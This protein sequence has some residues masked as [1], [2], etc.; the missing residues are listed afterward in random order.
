MTDEGISISVKEVQKKKV[1][2]AILLIEGSFTSVNEE[3]LRNALFSIDLTVE[4]I[5]IFFNKEHPENTN[6]C[7]LWTDEGIVTSVNEEQ[8]AKV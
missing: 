6:S 3:H 2:E 8:P 4:G 1:L 5:S 7:I